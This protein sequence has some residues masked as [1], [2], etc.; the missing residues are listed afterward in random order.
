MLTLIIR[1][2]AILIYIIY[3]VLY[4]PVIHPH[5]D[6]FLPLFINRQL[7]AP[8]AR[9]NITKHKTFM[10]SIIIKESFSGATRFNC[11]VITTSQIVKMYCKLTWPTKTKLQVASNPMPTTWSFETAASS[12]TFLTVEQTAS[13]TWYVTF[14][15]LS[16][17]SPNHHWIA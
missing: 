3:N 16:K 4:L 9:Y 14:N 12:T 5:D 1:A 7:G 8:L 10:F 17:I 13:H 11:M 15:P 2:A 6:I